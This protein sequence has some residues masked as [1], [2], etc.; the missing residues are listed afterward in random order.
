MKGVKFSLR[1]GEEQF[2][3]LSAGKRNI[4]TFL[5][6]RNEAFLIQKS[7]MTYNHYFD[8]SFDFLKLIWPF[9]LIKFKF[10]NLRSVEF[11]IRCDILDQWPK[12]LISMGCSIP[13][14]LIIESWF[15][16]F[17]REGKFFAE[18]ESI[19]WHFIRVGPIGPISIPHCGQKT[20]IRNKGDLLYSARVPV[21]RSGQ[22][23]SLYGVVKT[24]F[25]SPDSIQRFIWLPCWRVL[26]FWCV[27]AVRS[28]LV[29]FQI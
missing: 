12:T 6:E 9:S 24:E 8:A 16:P 23:H 7:E 5:K 2:S 28:G 29:K 10:W 13:S 20:G 15:A 1:K 22:D 17:R 26:S 14:C 25:I 27:L 3:Y 21:V 4:S 11:E 19:F 18:K